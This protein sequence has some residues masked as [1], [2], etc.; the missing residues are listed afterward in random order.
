M[1]PHVEQP[2]AH[3]FHSRVPESHQSQKLP[4]NVEVEQC[5]KFFDR[6][7]KRVAEVDAERAAEFTAMT[8]AQGRLQ[9]LKAEQ[10]AATSLPE[11][12]GPLLPSPDRAEIS[13]LKAK[14][15]EVE[16]QREVAMRSN[17]RPANVNT[18]GA[19]FAGCG[20][21]DKSAERVDWL[22]SCH[23]ELGEALGLGNESRVMELTSRLSDGSA[24]LS[25]LM[26]VML[27]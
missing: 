26:G 1:R 20:A 16:G 12:S 14:L 5:R 3:C 17:K 2:F 4:I 8:K 23:E 6:A 19:V 15:A 10:A 13:A 22:Q 24:K 7:E 27:P 25:E 21:P 18:V 11:P 9:R